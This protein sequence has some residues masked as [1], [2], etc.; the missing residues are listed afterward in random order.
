M[1]RIARLSRVLRLCFA[2]ALATLIV[3][4]GFAVAT[5]YQEAGRWAAVS[6]AAEAI[7]QGALLF[8][9][10]RLLALYQRGVLFESANARRFRTIALLVVAAALL[11][12]VRAPAGSLEVTFQVDF[13]AIVV[14]LFMLILSWVMFEAAKAADEQ[15]LT[16]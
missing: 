7:L 2:I 6:V 12:G 8:Q 15:R 1:D 11:P 13:N 9:G 16:V 3:I 4:A 14:G 10:E 5:E